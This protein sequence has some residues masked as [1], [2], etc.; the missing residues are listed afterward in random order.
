MTDMTLVALLSAG[1]GIGLLL[2][3]VVF[4]RGA[5]VKKQTPQ[6]HK[7]VVVAAN[8]ESVGGLRYPTGNAAMSS[9][10]SENNSGASWSQPTSERQAATAVIG[11]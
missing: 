2:V 11:D 4:S 5:Q 1:A 10:P 9:A 3:G 7:I 6:A 8:Q